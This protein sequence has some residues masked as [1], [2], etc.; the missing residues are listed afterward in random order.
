M[1]A[2]TCQTSGPNSVTLAAR[3]TLSVTVCDEQVMALAM[4]APL[5]EK[6]SMV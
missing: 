2:L 4:M 1:L 5:M 6:G 3:K